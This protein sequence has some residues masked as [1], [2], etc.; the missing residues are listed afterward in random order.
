MW[1]LCCINGGEPRGGRTTCESKGFRM[2]K[3]VAT[4]RAQ[5]ALS[6]ADQ[7]NF[8]IRILCCN[9]DRSRTHR[10]FLPC[11]RCF[12]QRAKNARRQRVIESALPALACDSRTA[13][14]K[15]CPFLVL[16]RIIGQRRPEQLLKKKGSGTIGVSGIRNFSANE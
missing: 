5:G 8:T 1:G 12:T 14:L 6:M 2:M 3:I 7:G 10:A 11:R 13:A 4:I 16:F 15:C 9:S